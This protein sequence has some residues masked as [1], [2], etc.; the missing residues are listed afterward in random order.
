MGLSKAVPGTIL[1]MIIT[2][3]HDKPL[4]FV[5]KYYEYSQT[6]QVCFRQNNPH[7]SH[8]ITCHDKPLKSNRVMW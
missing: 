2:N 7:G 1:H 8:L 6:Y 3:K 4:K 5:G